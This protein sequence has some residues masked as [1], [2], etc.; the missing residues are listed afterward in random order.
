M[1]QLNAKEAE[2]ERIMTLFRRGRCDL[3][4]AE[5]QL[6]AIARGSTKLRAM[7]DAASMQ[8]DLAK[9]WES[10][11]SDAAVLLG[12]LREQLEAIEAKDRPRYP[13]SRRRAPFPRDQR[14][15]RGH[16]L[17]EDCDRRC[18]LRLW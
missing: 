5:R 18:S 10:R 11:L 9:I 7:L 15:D 14:N 12:R 4:D 8:A 13:S 16:G 2:R 6:D 1:D 17:H 3:E